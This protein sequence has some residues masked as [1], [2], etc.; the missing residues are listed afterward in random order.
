[1]SVHIGSGRREANAWFHGRQGIKPAQTGKCG[2]EGLGMAAQYIRDFAEKFMSKRSELQIGWSDE[3][4]MRA[5]MFL[6]RYP[7]FTLYKTEDGKPQCIACRNPN[8][9]EWIGE[10]TN[11]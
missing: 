7:E 6:L 5:Y 8:Y 1:V 3:K 9:Y 2:L 10:E 11:V 4:R